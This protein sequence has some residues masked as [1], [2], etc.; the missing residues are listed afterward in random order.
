MKLKNL[1]EALDK[2]LGNDFKE[3]LDT[4]K[5]LDEEVLINLF[6]DDSLKDTIYAIYDGC[7]DYE[8]AD[9]SDPRV[10]KIEDILIKNGANRDSG[11]MF[12]GL[13]HDQ[14][15]NAFY[16]IQDYNDE[17]ISK[18]GRSL[19]VKADEIFDKHTF[20]ESLDINLKEALAD[21]NRDLLTSKAQ[22]AKRE[23]KRSDLYAICY[24]VRHNKKL[25]LNKSSF[26]FTAKDSDDYNDKV[27]K[28]C[29]GEK[30][31]NFQF[32]TVYNN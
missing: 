5:E 6:D 30:Q 8:D 10:V 4:K 7:F 2:L 3:E 27:A 19:N 21:D 29:N 26:I 28:Y 11:N 15:L 13:S 24:A 9:S 1:N 16:D 23:V 22:E 12:D 25:N 14:L 31:S 32:Y 18:R 20:D 17:Y